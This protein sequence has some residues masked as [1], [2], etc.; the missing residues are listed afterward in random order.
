M[1]VNSPLGTNPSFTATSVTQPPPPKPQPKP[2]QPV[3]THSNVLRLYHTDDAQVE[4]G[5]DE[6]ARGCLLGRVYAGAVIWDRNLVPT[7]PPK[8]VIRDSK[9]MSAKQRTAASEWIR[10]HAVAYAVAYRDERCV[11]HN[12]ILQATYSAMHEAVQELMKIDHPPQRLVVD[13]PQ[14]PPFRQA[15]GTYLYHTCVP[16]GDNTFFSIACAAIL[17]KVE[18]DLYIQQLCDV[19]PELETRYRLRSNV[20][21]GSRAHRD[22]ILKHGISQFHRKTFGLCAQ[23]PCVPV[24]PPPKP[25]QQ[26]KRKKCLE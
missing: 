20:G 6:V 4:C 1:A 7:L 11:E 14:F 9:K 21:Y 12:N 15:D 26:Q 8:V 16:G 24:E 19:Y 3:V 5:I 13:G 23:H 18:H 22:G 10:E 2:P 17:A 25:C